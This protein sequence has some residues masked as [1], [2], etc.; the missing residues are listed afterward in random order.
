MDVDAER[1]RLWISFWKASAKAAAAREAEADAL[2]RA[3]DHG[4]PR[5]QLPRVPDALRGLRCGART[6]KG[7]RC[8][9]GDL[10][11]SGRC[12]LHGGMSTGAT[13]PEG[14]A[15][16]RLNLA[17]RWEPMGGQQMATSEGHGPTGNDRSADPSTG[18]PR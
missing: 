8:K 7:S 4:E 13:T 14:Q 2:A 17:R 3:G 11:A 9:R 10:H 5:T 15:R 1:R 16:S 18:I 6:R 12:K